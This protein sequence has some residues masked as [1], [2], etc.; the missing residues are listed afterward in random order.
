[1]RKVLGG[2]VVVCSLLGG[3]IRAEGT[4]VGTAWQWIPLDQALAKATTEGKLVMVDVWAEHCAQ[5]G[6]MD[7]DVWDTAEGG[8]LTSN[9]IPI[10]V[11]SVTP[12]GQA[13]MSKY[14]ITGLP[15]VL[16]LRA[17]GS[18]VDRVTGYVTGA[19]WIHEARSLLESG[20]D[21]LPMLEAQ[22]AAHPDSTWLLL[23]VLER[24]LNRQRDD[25]AKALLTRITASTVSSSHHVAEKALLTMAKYQDYF[26]K[27]RDQALLYYQLLIEAYPKSSS[28]GGAVDGAY[29]AFAGSGRVGEWKSWACA[30]AE[31]N[32]TAGQLNYSI[33]MTASRYYVYDACLAKAARAARNSGLGS[34]TLDS[35]A[36][37]LEG[38]KPPVAR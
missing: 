28:V 30:I 5:C 38:G 1:M 32:P 34:A 15:A 4:A 24:Y 16:V 10:K 14:P 23:E 13:F 29:K 2:V 6:Q 7:I 20:H 26:R 12:E 31:A 22:L 36:V 17:D 9:V 3:V 35:I 11:N 19:A 21:P 18:E 25:E 8:K 37:V 27:D 33:A